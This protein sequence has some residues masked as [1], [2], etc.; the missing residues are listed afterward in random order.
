MNGVTQHKLS[1]ENLLRI[2]DLSD[3]DLA[4]I[5]ARARWFAECLTAKKPVPPSLAG[6]TQINLFF[7]DSTR[8]NLS[9]DL[10]GKKLGADVINV[11]VAASS[12]NKDEDI[13]DTVQTL[14]AMGAD[15]M[16]LRTRDPRAHE[17]LSQR[18]RCP[19]I[20]AGN[21]TIEHPTQALLDAATLTRTF[22]TLNGLTIAIC[23]DV[24]H[25]RVAGSGVQLF[26][27]LGATVRFVA[28]DDL[29]PDRELFA[30][31][32]RFS[33]LETGLDGAD[34]VMALRLQRER[35]ENPPP[36]EA[37][38]SE[39]RLDHDRLDLA[40]DGAKVMHPGPMNRGIEITASLAD[41]KARS[42]VLDQVF[43]GVATRMAV[44]DQLIV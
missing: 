40:K 15:V 30:D 44:L 39:F 36:I 6:R 18:T 33:T 34:V 27:R 41:D 5:L 35:M 23:G 32:E 3:D 37:Y 4:A 26:Q 17:R 14:D 13:L 24:R 9:F 29:L 43:M 2:D 31:T 7:E 1:C 42:L 25:S 10:A 20:N 22:G 28:P 16:I 12:V 21:G 19:V 11:P 38:I 8:T